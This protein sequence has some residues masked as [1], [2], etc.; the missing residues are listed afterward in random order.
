[1]KYLDGF[2]DRLLS[3]ARHTKRE[4]NYA[5][6]NNSGSEEDIG[7]F[8]NLL[9]RHRTSEYVYQEQNRVKHMLLK[10]CLDSVP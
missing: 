1:M 9:Q 4:Y 6:E 10:S 8:F 7:L 3:D 5:A 2:K